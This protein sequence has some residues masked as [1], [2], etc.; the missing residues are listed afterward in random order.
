MTVMA[1]SKTIAEA[2]RRILH[3]LSK[4]FDEG[5]MGSQMIRETKRAKKRRLNGSFRDPHHAQS[6]GIGGNCRK[7]PSSRALIAS[8]RAMSRSDGVSSLSIVY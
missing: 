6:L 8:W 2:I 5:T 1:A 4:I 3:K 7:I